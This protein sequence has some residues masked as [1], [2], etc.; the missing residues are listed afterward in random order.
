MVTRGTAATATVTETKRW[1]AVLAV[2]ALVA[3]AP[4]LV[5]RYLPFTDLPEHVA[6]IATMSRLLPGGGGSPDYELALG[7]SQYLLYDVAG[8]LLARVVGDA[9][10]A[11]RLLLSAIAFASPWAAWSLLR[12]LG[13]DERVA[14]LAPIIFWSRA[15]MIGFLPFVASIPLAVYTL[16]V[17]VRQIEAPARRRGA[18]LSFLALV[19]F[20]THVSSFVVFAF[21]GGAMTLVRV[22]PRRDLAR[23]LA[24]GLPMIPALVA[25]FVWWR[26][27][28]LVRAG[29]H[30]V[31]PHDPLHAVPLWAF[32]IW[33]SHVD[34]L[35][36]GLWWAAYLLLAAAGLR[37]AADAASLR[38]GAYA[39]IPIGCAALVYVLTP[40]QVGAAGFLDV[41]LAPMLAL[42]ALPLLRSVPGRASTIAFAV[43]AV[44]AV[45]TAVTATV[46][47]RRVEHAVV[48]D[49]DALLATMRPRTRVALLN[50]Q[51]GAPGVYFS[52]YPFAGSYHR[53]APGAVA[54]YSFT[55]VDHWPIHYR[56]GR[57]PPEHGEIFWVYHPCKFEYRRDGLYYDYLLVQGQRTP[58]ERVHP[59]PAFRERARAGAFTLL[60]KVSNEDLLPDAPDRGPCAPRSAAEEPPHRDADGDAEEDEEGD[61]ASLSRP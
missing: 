23:A 46:E 38:A 4:L 8:A 11:N 1:R 26:A 32:D 13:R 17:L 27:G 45:G 55:E 40:F 3:A 7:Q 61:D 34:E 50:F 21:A 29:Q 19:L 37:R 25:A 57:A 47:M 52:P 28:S 2:V 42:F 22:L 58:L 33:R 48:G 5:V 35:W 9:N 41:R 59:G 30:I 31:A 6:A 54:S 15:L 20:Y 44:A 51:Q 49:F 39:A 12:A 56:P 43:A 24:C 60:E 53:L 10:L 16:A 14:L 36:S 18:W